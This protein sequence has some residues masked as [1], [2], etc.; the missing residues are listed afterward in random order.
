MN[1]SD[2]RMWKNVDVQTVDYELGPGQPRRP[3]A[4]DFLA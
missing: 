2:S 4:T 1:E 3:S